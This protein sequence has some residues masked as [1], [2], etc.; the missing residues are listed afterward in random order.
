MMKTNPEAAQLWVVLHKLTNC[1]WFSKIFQ[2]KQIPWGVNKNAEM[3][4]FCGLI[5]KDLINDSSETW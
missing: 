2:V 5:K 4:T 1:L 3:L